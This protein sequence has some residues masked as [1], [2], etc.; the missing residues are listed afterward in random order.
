[1]PPAVSRLQVPEEKIKCV[2]QGC[3]GHLRP[4]AYLTFC[5]PS[6]KPGCLTPSL[7]VFGVWEEMGTKQAQ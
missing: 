6:V 1:M 7:L 3:R 2:D 4:L 5:F